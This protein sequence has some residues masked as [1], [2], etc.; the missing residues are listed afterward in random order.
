MVHRLSHR[1]RFSGLGFSFQRSSSQSQPCRG[2]RG[3]R[4]FR[5]EGLN[6]ELTLIWNRKRGFFQSAE[7]LMRKRRRDAIKI[8]YPCWAAS[9]LSLWHCGRW[10]HSDV[11][12]PI[13]NTWRMETCTHRP[14]HL[15][16]VCGYETSRKGE[17]LVLCLEQRLLQ[18]QNPRLPFLV[19]NVNKGSNLW[20]SSC[21]D[22]TRKTSRTRSEANSI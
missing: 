8:Q 2:G 22:R 20:E 14:G 16:H 1:V 4:C 3:A 10:V 12:P 11:T 17:D 18:V 19:L 13:A 7:G 9:A 15:P 6:V 21:Q 5:E